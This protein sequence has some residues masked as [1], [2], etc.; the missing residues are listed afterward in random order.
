MLY[1]SWEVDIF[2][3]VYVQLARSIISPYM[4]ITN[5]EIKDTTTLLVSKEIVYIMGLLQL[6]VLLIRVEGNILSLQFSNQQVL[7]VHGY[8]NV[9]L[10]NIWGIESHLLKSIVIINAD[11][12]NFRQ[13]ARC[14]INICSTP[15]PLT[16]LVVSVESHVIVDLL[17]T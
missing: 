15:M 11:V 5:Y 4:L 2:A 1:C 6:L 12:T 17:T 9:G 7:Y 16:S 14:Q 8:V 10:I 3:T 13:P